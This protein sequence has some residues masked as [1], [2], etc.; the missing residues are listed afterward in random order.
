MPFLVPR[1]S[2]V[3]ADWSVIFWIRTKLWPNLQLKVP[4]SYLPAG[5]RSGYN[6]CSNVSRRLF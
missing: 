2:L 4:L 5:C 6:G 1:V 3:P